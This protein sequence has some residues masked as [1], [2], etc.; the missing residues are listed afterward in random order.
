MKK[1]CVLGA[2][3]VGLFSA[4]NLLTDNDLDFILNNMVVFFL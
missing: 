4:A 1:V 2:G 3:Y